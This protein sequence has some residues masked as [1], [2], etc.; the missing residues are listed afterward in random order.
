MTLFCISVTIGVITKFACDDC[1]F[2]EA[3]KRILIGSGQVWIPGPT[4]D[5][6]AFKIY[7]LFLSFCIRIMFWLMLCAYVN[8]FHV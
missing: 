5:F 1:I 2:S 8:V 7:K 4:T 3:L 6:Y